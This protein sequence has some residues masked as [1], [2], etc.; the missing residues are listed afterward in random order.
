MP[1]EPLV[2]V[3][4]DAHPTVS[5]AILPESGKAFGADR[6]RNFGAR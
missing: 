3:V 2:V 5:W 4:G 6:E 1:T